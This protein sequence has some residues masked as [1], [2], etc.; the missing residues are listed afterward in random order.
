MLNHADWRVLPTHNYLLIQKTGFTYISN[1]FKSFYGNFSDDSYLVLPQESEKNICWTSIRNPYERF[2]SGL[3]Y[4]MWLTNVNCDYLF[5]N[6]PNLINGHISTYFRKSG[7]IQHTLSQVSYIMF[8]PISFFVDMND[9]TEFCFM[10]FGVMLGEDC[11]NKV[12]K[13]FKILIEKEIEKRGLTQ[14][15]QDL[16][17]YETYFYNRI[18]QSDHIWRWQNGNVLGTDL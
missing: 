15:V 16:L 5:S 12:P 7:K 9:L 17:S 1:V 10:N 2:I 11:Q 13:D 6:L 14:R 3:A 18:M 8:Q 4:D